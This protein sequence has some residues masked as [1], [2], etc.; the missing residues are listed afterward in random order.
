MVDN[1]SIYERC[2]SFVNRLYSGIHEGD[3]IN[4]SNKYLNSHVHDLDA[5]LVDY[6]YKYSSRLSLLL[7]L[8]T[9]QQGDGKKGDRGMKEILS[10]AGFIYDSSNV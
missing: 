9:I 5:S 7:I 4:R 10:R 1:A 8:L 6:W 2:G 3:Y